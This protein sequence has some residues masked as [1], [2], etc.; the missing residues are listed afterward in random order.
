MPRFGHD[1]HRLARRGAE[2][3]RRD[4]VDAGVHRAGEHSVLAVGRA[5]ERNHLDGVT[6][7]SEL[8]VEVDGDAVDELQGSDLEHFILGVNLRGKRDRERRD[9]DGQRKLE[10]PGEHEEPPAER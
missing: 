4:G 3:E 7:G 6:G 1:Q 5:L 2:Q 8:L 9:E 10:G